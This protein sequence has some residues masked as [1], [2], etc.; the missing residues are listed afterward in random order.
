MPTIDT[1]IREELKEWELE[2]TDK[3]GLPLF[4]KS[5]KMMAK[6]IAT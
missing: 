1:I 2:S 5:K 3:N 4:D 6:I